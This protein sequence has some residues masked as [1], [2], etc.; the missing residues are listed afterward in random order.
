MSFLTQLKVRAACPSPNLCIQKPGLTDSRSMTGRSNSSASSQLVRC[1]PTLST[2]WNTERAAESSFTSTIARTARCF[3]VLLATI[4]AVL[5]GA[6]SYRKVHLYIESR[7]DPLNEAFG[8]GWKRAPA[9]SAIRTILQGLEADDVE[10][11]FRIHA[12]KLAGSEWEAGADNA[13]RK[14]ENIDALRVIAIDGKTLRHSFD[15]FNDRKAAHI[16]SAFAV[17]DALILGHLDVG[18]KTNE[19][20]AAQEVIKA[21][22]LEGHLF[23]LDA[24]HCQNNFRGGSA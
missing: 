14:D 6:C 9:Y 18:E 22:A 2:F 5:S 1:K 4:L 11:T 15:G 16:L 13:P 3:V 8:F 19:V 10:R 7:L 20:P 23:T 12:A 17:E 24:M 21:L